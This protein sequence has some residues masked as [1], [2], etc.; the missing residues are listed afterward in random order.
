MA[1]FRNKHTDMIYD[2]P[3]QYD[4]IIECY[5]RNDDFEKVVEKVEKPAKASKKADKE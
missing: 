4:F 5:E 2:V 1:K 3:E